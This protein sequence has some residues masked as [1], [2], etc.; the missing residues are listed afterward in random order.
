MEDKSICKLWNYGTRVH[1]L[2]SEAEANCHNRRKRV[3]DII[4]VK[5]KRL[6]RAKRTIK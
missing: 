1:G 3:N 4:K 2:N 5:A 6:I